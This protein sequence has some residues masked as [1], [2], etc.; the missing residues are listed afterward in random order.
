MSDE[1]GPSPTRNRE[2]DA[3]KTRRALAK[4][5]RAVAQA[6]AAGVS[7]SAWESDFAESVEDR[8]ETYGSAFVDPAKGAREEALSTLQAQKL[9]EIARKSRAATREQRSPANGAAGEDLAG[10]GEQ[11]P[12]RRQGPWRSSKKMKGRGPRIRDV[13]AD[14][15]L[16]LDDAP[17]ALDRGPACAPTLKSRPPRSKGRPAFTLVRGGRED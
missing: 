7:L 14:L 17:A 2:V 4:V 5:R 12:K 9:R 3:R 16:T 1:D 11:R 15:A 8:L 6:E 10:D 13:D